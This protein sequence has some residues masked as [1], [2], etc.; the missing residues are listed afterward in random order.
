MFNSGNKSKFSLFHLLYQWL[1]KIKTRKQSKV[2]VARRKKVNNES[3]RARIKAQGWSLLEVP[4]KQRDHKTNKP[5][6]ARWKIVATK[7]QR[8]IEVG[9]K[10]IDEA[11]NN[12]GKTLGVISKDN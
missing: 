5:F 3:I 4:I 9:G 10:N 7:N 12:I 8:S 2:F 11:L 1:Q 6:I